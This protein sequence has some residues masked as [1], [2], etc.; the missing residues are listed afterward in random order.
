MAA[1]TKAATKTAAKVRTCNWKTDGETRCGLPLVR[2]SA[3]TCKEHAE[4]WMV[5]HGRKVSAFTTMTTAEI[6]RAK[7]ARAKTA[8]TKKASPAKPAA[9]RPATPKA[10][11]K[12]SPAD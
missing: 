5:A 7:A 4:A 12:A 10:P 9:K 6:S 11:A 2:P 1:Q 8:A 3:A